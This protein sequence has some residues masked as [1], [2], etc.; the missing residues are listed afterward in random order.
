MRTSKNNPMEL[1]SPTPPESPDA[2][3]DGAPFLPAYSLKTMTSLQPITRG[4]LSVDLFDTDHLERVE[5]ELDRIV[6]KRAREARDA[7]RVEELWAESAR[8]D[9]ERRREENREAWRSFHAHMQAL[10]AG[11]ASEHQEKAAKLDVGGEAMA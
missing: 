8:R 5:S 7:E 2:R 9:R 6:E 11:L 1:G 3:K 4:V 10:H